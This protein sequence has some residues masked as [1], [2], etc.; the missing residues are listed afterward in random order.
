MKPTAAHVEDGFVPLGPPARMRGLRSKFDQVSFRSRQK[1][2][3]IW[4]GHFQVST[5]PWR[6]RTPL[7]A[8]SSRGIV[9]PTEENTRANRRCKACV[10][11]TRT[12]H[13]LAVG[14]GVL[15]GGRAVQ[16]Q[17]QG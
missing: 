9:L 6:T 11:R 17:A 4:P 13:R 3:I 7:R 15:D 14:V 12:A 2:L 16:V 10:D 5:K 1:A 8:S